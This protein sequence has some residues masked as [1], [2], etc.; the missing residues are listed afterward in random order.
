ME[1]VEIYFDEIIKFS[2]N[3]EIL[4][5]IM[6]L[7]VITEEFKKHFS[8]EIAS[9]VWNE[10]ASLQLL[11]KAWNHRCFFYMILGTIYLP[12]IK[13]TVKKYCKL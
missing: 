4:K 8:N 3:H 12:Y 13:K 5:Q 1:M 7:Q 9:A 11:G 10:L 6:N 2:W